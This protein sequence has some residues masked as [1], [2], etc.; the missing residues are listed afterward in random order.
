MKSLGETFVLVLALF[1]SL[2][3]RFALSFVVPKKA[4]TTNHHYRQLERHSMVCLSL[5]VGSAAVVNPASLSVEE[6]S[7]ALL[8]L[9]VSNKEG[10]NER[11]RDLEMIL[12]QRLISAKV[13][14][15]PIQC[16]DGPLY[17]STVMEGPSP[18]W[19]G[20]GLSSSTNVQGQQYTYK[21]NEKSVVNYAEILG[22]GTP[23]SLQSRWITSSGDMFVANESFFACLC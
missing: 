10:G 7:Q 15:D 17:Y 23:N 12:V 1:Y 3:E 5:N 13:V 4:L 16:L 18:L 8:N 9:L 2:H 21:E 22:K 6:A 19:K 20:L 14:F 11:N